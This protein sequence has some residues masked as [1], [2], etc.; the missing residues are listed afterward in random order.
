MPN[1]STLVMSRNAD[2]FFKAIYTFV[3]FVQQIMLKTKV[4]K[5]IR[6]NITRQNSNKL[7]CINVLC[8]VTERV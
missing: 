6:Q 3:Q 5:N 2:I 8:L 4:I 1:N 7:F